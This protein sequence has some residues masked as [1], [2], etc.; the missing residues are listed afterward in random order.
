MVQVL[1]HC[2]QKLFGCCR[3]SA[4]VNFPGLWGEASLLD[5]WSASGY[6]VGMAKFQKAMGCKA[7][8][9][10]KSLKFWFLHWC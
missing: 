3:T 7:V 1:G 2:H 8:V 5:A 6:A 4:F 10:T 9:S